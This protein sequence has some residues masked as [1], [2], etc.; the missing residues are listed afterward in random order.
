MRRG[1]HNLKTSRMTAVSRALAALAACTIFGA[2]LARAETFTGPNVAASFAGWLTPHALPR[3]GLAPV[4]LHMRGALQA[5]GSREPPQLE[6]VTIAINRNGKLSTAGLPVCRWRLIQTT[7][8]AQALK[9]CRAALVGRGSFTAHIA[10]PSQAPFPARGRMLAFNSILGGRRVILAHI[11]GTE[12]LPTARVLVLRFLRRG[13]G[14][15][16]ITMTVRLPTA[17][18]NWGY[19]TGFRLTL[20]RRYTYRGRQLSFLSAG[21]P[22][23]R[24][25]PGASFTAARGI[26]YLADGRRISRLLHG[27]CTVSD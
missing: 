22:A 26:Y 9:A 10:L 1:D 3:N 5:V 7:T 21:C 6:R 17:T 20:R 16:G 2:G 27:T 12:P 19:A 8:T 18:V 14:T 11:Y 15:F 24:G 25:F 23:P 13:N 4:A